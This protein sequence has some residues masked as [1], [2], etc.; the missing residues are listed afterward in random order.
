VPGEAVRHELRVRPDS[1]APMSH[2]DHFFIGHDG[3]LLATMTDMV[4]VGS[5]ALNRLAGAGT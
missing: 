1:A 3:R 4:G 2:C 5:K